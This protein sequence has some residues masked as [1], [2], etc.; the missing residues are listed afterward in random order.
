MNLASWL[1]SLGLEQY[2]AAFRENAIDKP[3]SDVGERRQVTVMFSDMVGSTALS[4]AMDPEDLRDAL[5]STGTTMW[6]P[7]HLSGL[8]KIMAN[9]VE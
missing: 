4:V 8:A 1:R 6:S 2:E 3:P 9:S 7:L 5:R